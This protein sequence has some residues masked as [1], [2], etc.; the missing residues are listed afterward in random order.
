VFQRDICSS[1]VQC[2]QRPDTTP[3]QTSSHARR[4]LL[5]QPTT[6]PV[7]RHVPSHPILALAELPRSYSH[8]DRDYTVPRLCDIV[9]GSWR[10]AL[11][12]AVAFAVVLPPTT[13]LF[14]KST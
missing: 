6:L 10:P 14:V 9:F 1:L 5:L 4:Y 3:Q 8:I 2:S 11:A 12:V 13:A 7:P